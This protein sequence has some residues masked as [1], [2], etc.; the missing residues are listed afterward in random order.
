MVAE[1][2]G[3]LVGLLDMDIY[4]Q[5]YSRSYRY[6]PADK[7]AYFSNLAV[8]PDAQGKGVAQA[9]YA[10]AKEELL[11]KGVQKLAIFTRDGDAANHLY[12]K[13]GGKLVCQD[14]LVVGTPKGSPDF[15]FSVDLDQKCIRLTDD[16]GKALPFFQREGIYIVAKEGDLELF[17]IEQVYQ[18][19][20]YVVEL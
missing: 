16:Q 19:F 8:H 6:A 9:L 14:W 18:E 17:D 10:Q 4:N 12:Q 2:D 7:V 20:T 11:R 3:Q 1:E 13:W 15:H 5:T